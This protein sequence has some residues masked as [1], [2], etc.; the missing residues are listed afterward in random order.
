[1]PVSMLYMI[2]REQIRTM[3]MAEMRFVR[4]VTGCRM[5]ERKLHQI[6]TEASGLTDVNITIQEFV[7]TS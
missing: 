5:T 6:I 2:H 7:E 4:A 3:Q 1:M